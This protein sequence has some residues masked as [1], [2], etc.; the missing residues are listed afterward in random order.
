MKNATPI[1][2]IVNDPLRAVGLEKKYPNLHIVCIDYNEIVDWLV[3]DGVKVFCLEKELGTQNEMFRNTRDLLTRDEV[4]DYILTNSNDVVGLVFFKP[5]IGIEDALS[6]TVLSSKRQVKL[7]HPDSKLASKLENKIFFHELLEKHRIKHP[8]S[9]IK[10]LSSVSH[11]EVIGK[12]PNGYVIQFARGWFGNAT[13]FITAK[14]ELVSL[15]KDNR[16]RIVKISEYVPSTVLTNNI[17]VAKSQTYQTYPFLQ[18]TDQSGE[19]S[20]YRGSTVGNHWV[21]ADAMPFNNP[22]A[23]VEEVRNLTEMLGEVLRS[24]G[25]S[26][27]AGLD[28]LV[29]EEDEVF[30]QEIN[31]RFTASA[32]MITQMEMARF[33]NSLQ[34]LHFGLFGFNVSQKDPNPATFFEALSGVRVVARN[35]G[36]EELVIGTKFDNGVYSLSSESFDHVRAGYDVAS[37][38]DKEAIIYTASK[39][40]RVNTDQEIIQLQSLTLTKDEALQQVKKIKKELTHS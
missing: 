20:R 8:R 34:S 1:F 15:Q 37:L 31:P 27:F 29:S 14:D 28:F 33:G 26:G 5:M 9:F 32:E 23:V 40:R 16:D 24:Q 35:T 10:S 11:D 13:Y 7:L 25:Y 4:V 36:T 2:F 19:L 18:I 17:V 3:N 6:R 22:L 12:F 30:V 38:A 39:N 21:G